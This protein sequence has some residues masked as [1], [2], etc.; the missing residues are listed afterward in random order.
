[1]R[2]LIN[3]YLIWLLWGPDDT[4]KSVQGTAVYEYIFGVKVSE[5]QPKMILLI[6]KISFTLRYKVSRN[7]V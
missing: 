2:K 1:M 6:I 7:D 5:D 4:R 3:V